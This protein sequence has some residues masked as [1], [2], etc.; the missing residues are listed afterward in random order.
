MCF[1][2]ME[3]KETSKQKQK[4]SLFYVNRDSIEINFNIFWTYT[5]QLA[6]SMLLGISTFLFE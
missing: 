4:I 5:R 2:L 1:H 3:K 6:S